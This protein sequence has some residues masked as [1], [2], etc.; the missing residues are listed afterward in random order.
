MG[1]PNTVLVFSKRGAEPAANAAKV[2][3]EFLRK[4]KI[5]TIDLTDSDGPILAEEVKDV[6]LAVVIGGDGTFLTLVRRLVTKNR[7][8]IMG[9]NLGTLGFITDIPPDDML[10]AVEEALAGKYKEEA[11]CLMQVEICQKD[12]CR[13]SGMAFNDA[14]MTKDASTRMLKFDVWIGDEFLNPVRADGYIVSTPTG[15]SAYGA[16]A[17]GPLV[18]PS[19]NGLVLVPICPH[20]LTARPVVI[21]QT[22]QVRILPKDF[23]G[24]VFLVLDG[25]VGHEI[26]EKDEIRMRLSDVALRLLR[27]PKQD[28]SKTIR[29]KLATK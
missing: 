14:V 2:L 25:Q 17:G 12:V 19:V 8:P 4:K 10:V 9:V 28:W 3:T 29:T 24:K 11:R 13:T 6:K 18:H 1:T 27:Y 16:A 15:S 20:S 26:D 21:P 23:K 5:P 7:F 22:M